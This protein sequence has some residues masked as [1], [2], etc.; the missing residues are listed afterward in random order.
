MWK[1]T[2]FASSGLSLIDSQGRIKGG[3][4]LGKCQGPRAFGGPADFLGLAVVYG[5]MFFGTAPHGFGLTYYI[6]FGA[7][8]PHVLISNMN[9]VPFCVIS[10]KR[11][12]RMR[13]IAFQISNIFGGEPPDPPLIVEPWA[14]PRIATAIFSS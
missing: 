9:R 3:S 4:T 8:G 14:P 6:R 7:L 11:W 13:K 12:L 5:A 1:S 10:C 2:P